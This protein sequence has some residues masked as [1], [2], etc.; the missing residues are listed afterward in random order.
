[1]KKNFREVSVLAG[2]VALLL[3]MAMFTPNFFEPQPLLSRMTAA[4]P[5]L[6]L[7]C[8]VALVI[9]AR[10]ID[11]SIGSL[12]AVCGTCAGLM[13]AAKVPLALSM[14]AAI[15]IGAVGGILNGA[16]VAGLGLP[17]IVVTLATMVTMRE[18]LR[19]KQQGVFINLPEAAQWFSLSMRSGQVVVC[20]VAIGILLALAFAMRYLPAGRFVYAVGSDAEAARLAGIRPRVVTFA[21]FVLMGALAGLAAVLNMAQSPQVDPNS[22][23]G[24]ELEAIAA[25]VVGGVSVSGGRGKLWGVF[26]GLLLLVCIG[27]ALTYAGVKPHWERAIQGAI[28]VLAVMADGF[29]N[30]RARA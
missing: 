4:A 1:M 30:R 26:V 19:L 25:A 21:V 13:A 14:C 11:I 7:A 3:A 20:G 9:I 16:L 8:G 22:G 6:I 23:R 18:F 10:Q 28:I 2:L 29:R 17:S 27:P 24:M 5:R 15:G 12:F